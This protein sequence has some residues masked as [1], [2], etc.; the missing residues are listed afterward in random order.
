LFRNWIFSVGWIERKSTSVIFV[1]ML[2][3][4][5]AFSLL[6]QHGKEAWHEKGRERKVSLTE[7]AVNHRIEEW[8]LIVQETK[9]HLEL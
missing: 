4:K 6:S 5:L 9:A 2:V 3:L 1:F 7:T 8:R